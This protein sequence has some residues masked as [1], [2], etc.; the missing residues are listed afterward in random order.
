MKRY[1]KLLADHRIAVALGVVIG[2]VVGA[3][4]GDTWLGV[5]SG[6]TAAFV[7]SWL[8]KAGWLDALASTPR[9]VTKSGL[10][11]W[12]GR[13]QRAFERQKRHDKKLLRL[14]QDR[15]IEKAISA[16]RA[17]NSQAD[18]YWRML[19]YVNGG[20]PEKQNW[21]LLVE[22]LYMIPVVIGF[23]GLVLASVV[24]EAVAFT[25]NLLV[26][27]VGITLPLMWLVVKKQSRTVNYRLSA[28]ADRGQFWIVERLRSVI[29]TADARGQQ[30]P[31]KQLER[32]AEALMTS[33]S[34]LSN[35][36]PLMQSYVCGEVSLA[37]IRVLSR[38]Y[39]VLDLFW[40]LLIYPVLLTL[41]AVFV[42]SNH[43]TRIVAST[44]AIVTGVYL[45]IVYLYLGGIDW[46]NNAFR[47]GLLIAIFAA[48]LIVRGLASDTGRPFK[49]VFESPKAWPLRVKNL[50]V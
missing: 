41:R 38:L 7:T 17:R 13:E 44:A 30:Y 11:W 36:A 50:K 5:V 35:Y 15:A 21:W 8:L 3:Y 43:Q 20:V 24:P 14:K 46:S 9:A 25:T 45:S 48:V 26:L 42:V 4:I 1:L 18:R 23:V 39:P 49:V 40:L 31:S 47:W 10:Q 16:A 19:T 37:K 12:A 33:H 2:A 32:Y 27:L 22:D 28:T 6:V 34:K 29:V